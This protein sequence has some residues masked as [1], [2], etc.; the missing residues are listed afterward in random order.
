M[1]YMARRAIDEE[2]QGKTLGYSKNQARKQMH[3]TDID[4]SLDQYKVW[5]LS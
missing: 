1:I 5:E 3:I 2:H 4:N